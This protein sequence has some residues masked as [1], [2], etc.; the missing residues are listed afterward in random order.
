MQPI[1]D[2][3]W[4]TENPRLNN[5]GTS[6][7]TKYYYYKKSSNKMSP[8]DTLLIDQ[9]F[10]QPSS[11]KLHPGAYG[12][13]FRNPQ[14]D[15]MQRARTLGTLSLKWDGSMKP[16]GSGKPLGEETG[17]GEAEGMKD[18]RRTKTFKTTEQNSYE[19]T[20]TE[21]ACTGTGW[22]CTSSSEYLLR[23]PT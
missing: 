1:P 19:L 2:T 10:A 16:H 15:I 14:A 18:V 12:N 5:P 9:C 3:S 11:E 4:V 8:N 20:E 23:L 22:V 21:A 17:M 6:S 7:K 13:K